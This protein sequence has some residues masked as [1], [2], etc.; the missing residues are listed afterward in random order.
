METITVK[1]AVA[2]LPFSTQA[3]HED[4]WYYCI[5]CGQGFGTADGVVH[6]S[7]APCAIRG[8]DNGMGSPTT[9]RPLVPRYLQPA[10]AIRVYIAGPILTSGN[11]F[12]NIRRAIRTAST[13]KKRGYAPYIPH[14]TCIWELATDEDFSYEDWI[15]LDLE[16]LA[17]C[18]AV[19]RLEGESKGADR[20]VAR[21]RELG[22]TV[23]YSLDSLVAGQHGDS[24]ARGNR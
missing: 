2:G 5:R 3:R 19:L 1:G 24:D 12:L 22:I 20:E 9:V 16:W 21:A 10:S 4:G 7:A 18:Q 6:H 14:L 13:L 23:Y 15:G 17:Q 8:I 11:P